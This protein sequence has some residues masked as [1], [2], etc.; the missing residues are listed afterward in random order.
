MGRGIAFT[1][2]VRHYGATWAEPL[3]AMV[4]NARPGSRCDRERSQSLLKSPRSDFWKPIAPDRH[5]KVGSKGNT[6]L[7]P[8]RMVL[9]FGGLAQAML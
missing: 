6:A 1:Q 2:I 9:A 7:A 3:E 5:R 4:A 8:S